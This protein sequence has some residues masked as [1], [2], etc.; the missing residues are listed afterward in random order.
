[1][2]EWQ[3]M[4]NGDEIALHSVVHVPE[5]LRALLREVCPQCK[6]H[7]HTPVVMASGFQGLVHKLAAT[8]HSFVLG[9]D[10]IQRLSEYLDTFVAITSDM[11]CEFRFA[12]FRIQSIESL[13][14]RWFNLAEDVCDMDCDL[15]EG[16]DE[17][18]CDVDL[19]SEPDRLGDGDVGADFAK[20]FVFRFAMAVPGVLHIVHNLCK[21]MHHAYPGWDALW[22]TLKNFEALLTKKFRRQRFINSCIQ[23]IRD[24]P[25]ESLASLNSFSQSLYEKRWGCV[26]QFI[27]HLAPFLP[28]CVVHGLM[29]N[30]LPM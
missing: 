23:D 9:R 14:P 27:S 29:R 19:G 12:D 18:Q 13:L 17:D 26:L 1:M 11:V 8:I 4:E 24:V 25:Q 28:L 6:V 10:G 30:V 22:E 15:S 7:T 3:E 2:L 16:G 5:D 20:Q 21:D